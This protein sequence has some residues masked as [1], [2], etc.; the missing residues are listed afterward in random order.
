MTCTFKQMKAALFHFENKS[1]PSDFAF[2]PR[3]GT[4]Y[5]PTLCYGFR[6]ED[7]FDPIFG[8]VTFHNFHAIALPVAG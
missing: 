7:L 6:G 8:T 5:D 2:H 3:N 1:L 4:P